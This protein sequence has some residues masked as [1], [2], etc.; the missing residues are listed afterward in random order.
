MELPNIRDE[1]GQ[2]SAEYV[3]ITAVAIVVA[4]GIGWFVFGGVLSSALSDLGD[5]LNT[6][7]DSLFP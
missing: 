7:I 3:A 4:I 6:T 1:R 2:T 5:M